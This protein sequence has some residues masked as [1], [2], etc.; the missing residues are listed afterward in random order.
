MADYGI[1]FQIT[2]GL[3]APLNFLKFVSAE[4]D[5]CTYDGPA[6]IPSDGQPHAVHLAD[7]CFA[8]GAE[9]TAYFYAVVQ[10]QRRQYGWYGN[11]PVW[12]AGNGASGPG[13]LTW[14]GDGHPLTV[15]VAVDPQ[16][17]GWTLLDQ[18]VQHVF[19]LMLENR[20][21][22][23]L[24]G[25]SGITGTDAETGQPA[26][27]NGL[28]GEESN[29]YNGTSYTVS[30]PADWGMPVDPGHE[31]PDVLIQLCGPGAVYQP[32][33]AYPPV[34]NSGFVV[35]YV[36]SGGSDNPAEIMKCYAPRQLPVLTALAQEFAVCDGWRAS[37]PGP[38]WPNRF[39]A[40]AA[41][42]GGLDHS[43]STDQILLWES[44]SGFSFQNGTIF[45]ALSRGNKTWRI[46]RGDTGDISGSL[47]IASALKGVRIF[48][49]ARYSEFP[50]DVSGNYPWEFTFIEPNYGNAA[51]DTY[52]GGTSQHPLDD[53]RRGEGLLKSTYEALRN[54]PLWN[55]SLLIVTWDEHGGFYDHAAVVPDGAPSPGDQI[56]TPGNVN[57]HGF[58]F[59]QYGPR[60]PAV[61]V[62]PLIPR[63]LIDH[64]T[65]DH[66]S[67]PATVEKIF[68]LAPL[69][70]RDR[71]ARDV[72]SLV[73]LT[74]PRAAP[75][76][77]PDPAPSGAAPAAAAARAIGRAADEPVSQGNLPGFLHIALRADLQLSP[78]GEQQAKIARVTSISTRGEAEDYLREVGEKVATAKPALALPQAPG[79]QARTSAAG[80]SFGAYLA[81][82]N[83]TSVMLTHWSARITSRDGSWS[84]SI[85]SEQPGE[86]LQTPDLSGVFDVTVV[87]SGPH[88]PEK[89]LAPL[90]ESR[91]DIS[92][93]SHHRA[94][95]GIV[96]A[97]DGR[98]AEYWTA[99]NTVGTPDG[100]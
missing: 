39:F 34:D 8:T 90:R 58:T 22:D 53:V 59:Q 55:T 38:T 62:S 56:V 82:E 6:S 74:V 81:P 69:T 32:G 83:T 84:G 19:V 89:Q 66:S 3:G 35:D 57:Q 14:N 15:T 51:N 2:N 42:S 30:Q 70:Q 50:A 5:C 29:Q 72:T 63:N 93:D 98:D 100:A 54:S 95:V 52:L 7:P 91:A 73:S 41:S 44:F 11:C 43:P 20:S 9:G 25:F 16:T 37:M 68:G 10:G 75:A 86:I 33:G 67:I 1:Y 24:L 71:H 65:Y 28:S 46:Y 94:M 36:S 48:D 64:R 27:I 47:P 26:A 13:V 76:R 99:G 21:F 31:F 88:M 85:T 23:H 87:A 45:D 77:L 97:P 78:P 40:V 12:S 18:L 92:C 79:A 60:V 80:A 4:G 17:P 49:V 61:I 96:A